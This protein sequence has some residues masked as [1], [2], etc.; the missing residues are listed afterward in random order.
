LE[1]PGDGKF[2]L[3]G[4][5]GLI[6]FLMWQH[7]TATVGGGTF[8]HDDDSGATARGGCSGRQWM[9]QRSIE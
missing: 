1:A 9:R 8:S 7:G 6:L 4:M 2:P 3:G 5:K